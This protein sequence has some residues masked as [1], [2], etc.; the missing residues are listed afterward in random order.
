MKQRKGKL[1]WR[2]KGIYLDLLTTSKQKTGISGDGMSAEQHDACRLAKT[3][4]QSGSLIE[5]HRR[6]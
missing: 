1:A 5:R 6:K 2:N 3:A 4:N